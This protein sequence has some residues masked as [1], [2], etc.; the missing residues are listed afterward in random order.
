VLADTH[1]KMSVDERFPP[2]LLDELERA[3]LILHAGDVTTAAALESLHAYAPLIAVLGNND[4]ALVGVLEPVQEFSIEGVAVAMIHDSGP[5]AGRPKRMRHRFPT[6]D[7]VVYGHSHVPDDSLGLEGQRLFNPGSPTTRRAQPYCT[8][9]VI[10][11]EAGLIAECR[12][13]P[14]AESATRRSEPGR[15]GEP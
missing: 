4:D 5:T 9:G 10:E 12:I 3:E 11:I 15:R 7:L 1:L 6:A 2:A 8:Y 14:L 13:E